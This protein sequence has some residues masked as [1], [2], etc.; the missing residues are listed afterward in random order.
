VSYLPLLIKEI[1]QKD[2]YHFFIRW[3]DD[4]IGIYQ[5]ANLQRNCPCRSCRDDKTGAFIKNIQ[6]ISETLSAKK[7]V[8]I[9]NYALRIEFSEGCQSGIYTY[10][11]LRKLSCLEKN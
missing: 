3:N 2:R 8:S 9:G 7:L 1:Y 5:L 11:F 6:E 10:S 4:K